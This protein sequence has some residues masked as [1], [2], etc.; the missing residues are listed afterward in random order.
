MNRL[1]IFS[2]LVLLGACLSE[3]KADLAKPSTFTRYFSDGYQNTAVTIEE[4]ADTETS[5][6]GFIILANS[7]IQNSNA[8]PLRNKI[9]LIK[10]DQFGNEVWRMHYPEISADTKLYMGHSLIIL[11]AGTALPKGGYLITGEEIVHV[12]GEED[13]KHLLLLVVDENGVVK[14]TLPSPYIFPADKSIIGQ[15]S[16]LGPNGNYIVLA[17]APPLTLGNNIFVAEIYPLGHA[18]ALDT[19]WT[20][21]YGQGTSNLANKVFYSEATNPPTIYW[22]GDTRQFAGLSGGFVT[23]SE[24]DTET[25]GNGQTDR[26]GPTASNIF[27]GDFC[28]KGETFGFVG[29][30]EANDAG[31]IAFYSVLSTGSPGSSQEIYTTTIFNDP[32]VT[33]DKN[34]KKEVANSISPTT[35]GGYIILGTIDSYTDPILGAGDTDMLLL[36]I[37]GFGDKE[38]TRTYGSL[39]ADGGNCIRQTTD[40]GYIVLGTSNFGAQATIL[41]IKTDKN[42]EVD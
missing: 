20:R 11:P 7:E 21:N 12:D 39:Q 38:W 14:N 36:K 10:T 13:L 34:N 31:D 16:A 25:P 5:Q 35:E 15:S 22:G 30:T 32:T 4:T 8:E 24:L 18:K 33:A 9:L 37:N 40:G 2:L 29:S 27:A 42:G 28:R 17:S 1:L 19:V 41:L 3:E 6:T 26:I 23:R